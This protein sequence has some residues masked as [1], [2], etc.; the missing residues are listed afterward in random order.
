[1]KIA[2]VDAI[3]LAIPWRPTDPPSP[4]TAGLGRQIL[5][6]VGTDEG[7]V[8]WG[9]AFALGAPAA[10]CA[11]VHEAL[12]P[13]LVGQ[14]AAEIER[15][16]DRLHRATLVFGRRGLGMFAISGVELALWDLAGQAQGLPVY[17]LLGGL[18][19]P[20]LP[21]YASLARFE[22]PA[23]VG[24]AA[25]AAAAE[26]FRGVK[27]HQTD[28]AS[29]AAARAALGPAVA[30]MLDVNCPWTP[31]QAIEMG[32]ALAPFD[33]AWLEEPVWPPEDYAGLARVAA[34][35][36]IP[37]AAGENEATAVGFRAMLAAGA[38]DIVQPSP[39]KVG[40]LGEARASPRSPP[41]RTSRWSLIR[42]TLARASRPR[43]T[44]RRRPPACPGSN[45]PWASSPRRSWRSRSGPWGVGSRPPPPRGSGCAR[46]PSPSGVTPSAPPAFPCS[47]P[48]NRSTA[49]RRRF[50]EAQA[51]QVILVPVFLSVIKTLGIDP[52]H[53]GVV[54]V[55]NLVIR[56]L[57]PP[58]GIVLF[59]RRL[60]LGL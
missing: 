22:R 50:M 12:R 49:D 28:V 55:L 27:L 36:A 19:Q 24:R 16:M 10:V 37:V 60:V 53:F 1:M 54:M 15:L 20:R 58:I 6:R 7:L 51:A 4:W 56:T 13:L 47:R 39:T 48:C 25:A 30:L 57:T 11:V 44:W 14:P 33:L 40:G 52:V 34:A 59:L 8:G 35:L 9:E 5:V 41:R 42:S 38:A 17:A 3:P 46:T 29:V 23:E 26:G 2:A 45:G 18:A 31:D 21:A 43:S 32:R